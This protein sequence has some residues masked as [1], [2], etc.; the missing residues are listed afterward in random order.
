MQVPLVRQYVR[1]MKNNAGSA[2]VLMPQYVSYEI[3]FSTSDL[4]LP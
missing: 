2:S 3:I 4:L 1:N